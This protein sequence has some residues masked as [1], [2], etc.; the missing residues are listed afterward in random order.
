MNY[1][2]AKLALIAL[3]GWNGPV[4]EAVSAQDAKDASPT[5]HET[6]SPSSYVFLQKFPLQRT[7]GFIFHTEVLV[8]DRSGF[9]PDDQTLLDDKVASLE[10][11]VE[12]DENWWTTQT[13]NCVEFGYGGAMCNEHCCG[14][15]HHDA[16]KNFPLNDRRAVISNA[17]TSQKSLFLYGVSTALDGEAAY[18]RLCDHKCWSNWAGTD[19]NPLTNNC[20]TLT[21]TV[22]HCV[23]G[24]S[25]KKPNL[26]P[27][28]MVK[29]T[30]DKCPAAAAAAA[31][32]VDIR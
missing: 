2:K 3:V 22:L 9:A 14:V 27:S 8:C 7:N 26:G 31:A 6:P 12:L 4:M 11:F 15:P 25:E 10:D 1:L 24:L 30:C 21:S 32:K 17:D 23:F 16:Q 18:H 28:D 29:V 20:N 13:A 5:T 19:Y